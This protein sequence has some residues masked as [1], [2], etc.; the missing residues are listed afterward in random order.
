MN[1]TS[2]FKKAFRNRRLSR[3]QYGQQNLL[4]KIRYKE[5]FSLFVFKIKIIY[6]EK[7]K[8]ASVRKAQLQRELSASISS[9]KQSRAGSACSSRLHA[10]SSS[11][12]S[13]N[14][15]NE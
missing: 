6:F 8:I 15:S 14:D 10:S 7:V 4:I 13:Q 5:K 9:L 12:L 3:I 2:F 1:V 11:T